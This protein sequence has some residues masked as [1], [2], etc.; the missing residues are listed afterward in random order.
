ML[1]IFLSITFILILLMSEDSEEKRLKN[2][3]KDWK[4][5]IGEDYY[6]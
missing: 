1:F 5:I 4:N 6:G 3:N 2:E